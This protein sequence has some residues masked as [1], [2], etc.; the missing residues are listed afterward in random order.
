MTALDWSDCD[1]PAELA[2]AKQRARQMLDDFYANRI[3]FNDSF[4]DCMDLLAD[5][6]PRG[7]VVE[8]DATGT[9]RFTR[10]DRS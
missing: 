2:H 10:F 9:T 6:D 3:E 7:V 1:G 8:I 4:F 5:E